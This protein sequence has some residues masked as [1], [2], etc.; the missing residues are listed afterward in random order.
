MGYVLQRSIFRIVDKFSVLLPF[1]AFN[2]N[3]VGVH[4]FLLLPGW[5]GSQSHDSPVDRYYE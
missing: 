1:S 5:D 2:A 4:V 3:L